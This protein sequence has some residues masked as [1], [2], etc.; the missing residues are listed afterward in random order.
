MVKGGDVSGGVVILVRSFSGF[1]LRF[2]RYG[3]VSMGKS[4]LTSVEVR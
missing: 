3:R 4:C 1:K 2:G